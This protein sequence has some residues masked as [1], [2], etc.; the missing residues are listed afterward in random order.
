MRQLLVAAPFLLGMAA[1]TAAPAATSSPA[2]PAGVVDVGLERLTDANPVRSEAATI[3]I[4]FDAAEAA[5]MVDAPPPIDYAGQALL[6]V[7][8]GERPTG[9]WSLVIQSI[10][11]DSR[12]MSILAREGRPRTGTG[13]TQAATYPA[14]CAVIDRSVLPVGEL[15]VR[16]DDTISDEFIVDATIEVPSR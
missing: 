6:C 4:A 9:G 10:S 14:D 1:C 2:S 13:T 15:T 3:R 7:Y 5:A 16:A 11:L 12:Q 8:L